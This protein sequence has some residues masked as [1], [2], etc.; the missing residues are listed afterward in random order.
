MILR[1]RIFWTGFVLI[2]AYHVYNGLAAWYPALPAF[3]GRINIAP[4]SVLFPN[5]RQV[6]NSYGVF[7]PP[8]YFSVIAFAFFLDSRISLSLGLSNLAWVMFGAFLIGN[9]MQVGNS[10][11]GAQNANFIRF[12]AYVGIAVMILYTGRRFFR[13]AVLATLGI[14]SGAQVPPY[15]AWAGRGL[16]AATAAA[17]W[18]LYT[19]GLSMFWSLLLTGTVLLVFLVMG[20]MVAETGLFFLKPQWMPVGIFTAMFG[21]E[22]IGPTQYILMALA[23]TLLLGDPRETLMPFILNGL[24]LGE[25]APGGDSR[26]GTG[27]LG[28]ALLL[29]VF[30]SFFVAGAVT[31]TTQYNRGL[32]SDTFGNRSIPA[33]PFQFL[34]RQVSELASRG[35]LSEVTAATAAGTP[36]RPS[37]EPGALPWIFGGVAVVLLFA[38]ARLRFSKWPFHPVIFL[39]WGT[40]PIIRFGTSFLIGWM[41]KEAV[42]NTTGAKGFRTLKPLMVGVIAAEVLAAIGWGTVAL[43]YYRNTGLPP[44]NYF[45]FPR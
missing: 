3:S 13:D 5:A 1:N 25:S 30:V 34:D 9:G 2:A 26:G 10:L 31:M 8:I 32:S 41:I 35:M 43:L 37:P 42:V 38:F 20:R 33:V 14:G 16:A 24:K 22:M 18:G 39:V 15:V 36:F 17:V 6:T 27:R 44:I 4:L 11:M 40:V 21:F 45:I 7:S 23:C 28:A 12:G 19:T 29:M